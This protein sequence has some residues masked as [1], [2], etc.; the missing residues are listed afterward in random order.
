MSDSL[1]VEPEEKE[2]SIENQ[3]EV[4]ENIADQNIQKEENIV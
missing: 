2:V 3:K 4:E 1:M